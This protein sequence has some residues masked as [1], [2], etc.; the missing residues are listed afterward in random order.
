MEHLDLASIVREIFI[1]IAK[2]LDYCHTK[3]NIVH[4][5]VSVENIIIQKGEEHGEFIHIL[6]DWGISKH[7]GSDWIN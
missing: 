6:I 2:L 5:D 1:P 4:R 3:E 7:V